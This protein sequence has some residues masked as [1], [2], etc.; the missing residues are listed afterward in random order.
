MTD[1]KYYNETER[2][3]VRSAEPRDAAALAIGRSCGFVKRYNLYRDCGEEQM[4][5]E[6]ENYDNVVLERKDN[7]AVIGCISI[8]EDDFRYRTDALLL[9]AW[10]SEDTAYRGYMREAI[11][12]LMEYL[13]E[14]YTCR[15][16]ARAFSENSPSIALLKK[17]GFVS[18]GYL[19]D[20]L[21]NDNG[22]TFDVCLYTMSKKEFSDFYKK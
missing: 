5:L 8:R 11:V 13:F 17:L 19:R 2:L 12:P 9:Q 7:G 16:S 15:I 20:A 1:F 21:V 4:L 3:I 22:K 18:E 10:L 14:N 6:L